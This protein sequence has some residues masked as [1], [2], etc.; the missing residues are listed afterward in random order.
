MKISIKWVRILNFG[1]IPFTN[2][3]IYF[4][5]GPPDLIYKKNYVTTYFSSGHEDFPKRT[6]KLHGKEIIWDHFIALFVSWEQTY[7]TSIQT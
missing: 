2:G 3:S 6:V 5:S 4:I 7:S 1:L